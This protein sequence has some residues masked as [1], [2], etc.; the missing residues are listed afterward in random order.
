MELLIAVAVLA[1][2]LRRDPLRAQVAA[3]WADVGGPAS[4]LGL[5][6]SRGRVPLQV[7]PRLVYVSTSALG[8]LLPTDPTARA[9]ALR[10]ALAHEL[11]HDPAR[12]DTRQEELDADLYAGRVLRA[13]GV[14]WADVLLGVEPMLTD[15]YTHGTAR[16]R[17][18][19]IQAGYRET[20]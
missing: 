12:G 13:R 2:A 11:G 16:E 3:A 1:L 19:A 14:P 7:S 18:A 6:W 17:M 8:P 5:T 15:S 10:W 9:A 4:P 20:P